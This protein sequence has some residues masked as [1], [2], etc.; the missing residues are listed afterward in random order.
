MWY[1]VRVVFRFAIPTLFI[2]I[3]TLEV[4]ANL[5]WQPM[6]AC[7]PSRDSTFKR[8]FG[9]RNEVS[10]T[11]THAEQIHRHSRSPHN[12]HDHRS[13]TIIA[14]PQQHAQRTTLVFCE[15]KLVLW[16]RVVYNLTREALLQFIIF[17]RIKHKS[18]FVWN[19]SIFNCFDF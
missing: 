3:S 7:L 8:L 5:V 13:H 2:M 15:C 10:H 16:V 6:M 1:N 19:S 9:Q 4:L 18:R 11:Q 12:T 14:R 17:R